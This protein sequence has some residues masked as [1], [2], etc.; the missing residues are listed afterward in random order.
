MSAIYNEAYYHSGC[1]PIPYENPEH[2]VEFFGGVASKIVQDLHPKTVLDAGCAMGYLVAALRD[3]G[4][5]AY[6]VDISDYAISMVRDDIRPY[7]FVGSLTEKLP[8]GMPE[9]YDLVVTIEVLEHL[10]AEDGEKA[11]QNLCR[12]SDTVLFS[13]TPDDFTERTHVNVQQREYWAKL[14]AQN[15]FFDDVLYS[16]KYI[17]QHALIFRKTTDIVGVVR[18]YEQS[19]RSRMEM[20]GA[21]ESVIYFDLGQGENET[22]CIRFT[23]YKQKR[24]VQRIMLP[25]G[26]KAV[27]L[28]PFRGVCGF[29]YDLQIRSI[30][31]VLEVSSHNGIKIADLYLFG[32]HDPQ[33]RVN[34]QEISTPWLEMSAEI[35][36]IGQ[37]GWLELYKNILTI[38]SMLENKEQ[39]CRDIQTKSEQAIQSVILQKEKEYQELLEHESAEKKQIC[40]QVET[41]ALQKV[42][43]LQNKYSDLQSKYERTK[44]KLTGEILDIQ[45]NKE[46]LEE[47]NEQ[48]SE[49]I[50]NLETNITNLKSEIQDYSNLVAYERAEH[51]KIVEVY[52]AIV[53]STTWRATKPI[54]VVLTIVKN[55]FFVPAKKVLNSLQQYGIRATYSKIKN[56]LLGRKVQEALAVNTSIVTPT[57]NAINQVTKIPMTGN[58]I[59]PMQIV[60]VKDSVKRI[61]L[62]TDTIDAG[63]LLGGVATALIVA[64]EFA[65]QFG[66][67]LRIITRN[68]AVNPLNYQNIIRISG[69][70]PA[71]KISYYSDEM[72]H[73]EPVDFKLE[74]CEG[75]IFFATSWW[76]AKAIEGIVGK[77]RFFYIIQEVE[78]FFYN[79]G[80][81]R[82]LC[83]QMMEANNIDYLIN[84][85]YLYDY[86][87]ENTPH[88]VQNGCYFE[89]AFPS[90]LYKCKKFEAKTHYKLFFYARPNN[91]RNLYSFGVEMLDK[92][93]DQG[94][95][96]TKTWDIFCVGQN[97]PQITFCNGAQSINLGQLSWT[98]YAEFLSDVDLGLCLMYTPHPSYPPFDVACSGG[99]VLSNQMMNKVTFKECKNVI[100][101]ELE[102]SK[103]IKAFSKAIQLAQDPEERKKNFEENTIPRDWH[104]TLKDTMTYMGEC[105]ESV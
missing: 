52:T 12:L 38:Q 40:E 81:E 86:F 47:N 72:R 10:Y 101:A 8:K 22:D 89:P 53:N 103:F 88:I 77:K 36:L 34:T 17:S 98:E 55:T 3:R 95:L 56:R 7:C 105:R 1:G 46:D 24:F 94:I 30:D 42:Q 102:E 61:N 74:I 37:T 60:W 16:P 5:E 26:C 82:L 31:K 18:E 64:T 35:T 70:K 96:D 78:T 73:S 58:P 57:A 6:G 33:I 93:I 23:T 51:R 84:S 83:E 63:S 100:M 66:Y 14:F 75:D 99:V 2:W 71:Q 65:N 97:A 28:T 4:V 85:Q 32:T 90:A 92:A 27:R 11:I 76:S 68:S 9:R 54:R 44:D 13:S 48:L 80:S 19:I 41:D 49:Q 87:K 50:R 25:K 21:Y 45:R 43:E 39:E 15:G 29:V 91:P 79:Y 104:K 20:E 69:I 59:D 62:V 67:E